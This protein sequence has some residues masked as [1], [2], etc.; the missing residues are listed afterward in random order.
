[1]AT[2]QREKQA[3]LN[4]LPADVLLHAGRCLHLLG[5]KLATDGGAGL[6]FSQAALDRLE[7]RAQVWAGPLGLE[8]R[9]RRAWTVGVPWAWTVGTPG[10]VRSPLPPGGTY[11]PSP[12]ASALQPAPL[13][14]DPKPCCVVTGAG[15]GARGAAHGPARPAA[16]RLGPGRR[17]GS[18]GAAAGGA[19]GQVGAGPRWWGLQSMRGGGGV[20]VPCAC[21][22]QQAVPWLAC[23]LLPCCPSP[24]PT[25]PSPPPLPP[26][27]GFRC[28]DVQ[29]LKFGM[30]LP[31]AVLDA[32]GEDQEVPQALTELRQALKDQEATQVGWVLGGGGQELDLTPT[33]PP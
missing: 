23:T 14:P 22:T 17:Q 24:P 12:A 20:H 1:M 10:P 7:G 19:E 6:V 28:R 21:G 31:Q 25:L 32:L 27:L 30:E 11:A 16:R 26:P 13:P 33:G 5:G 18:Q 29:L 4:S 8:G 9:G 2:F 15:R 3:A